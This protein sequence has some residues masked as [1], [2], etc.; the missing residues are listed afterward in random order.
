MNDLFSQIKNIFGLFVLSL[1]VACQ[2]PEYTGSAVVS[3]NL[4]DASAT[5]STITGTGPVTADGISTSTITI[6]IK[7]GYDQAMPGVTPTFSATNTGSTNTYG[8]CT[9]TDALG[10]STCT[11][12]STRAEVKTLFIVSPVLKPDGAVIFTAG[13]VSAATSTISGSTPNLADGIDTATV[14]ITL[15]DA[16]SNPISGT[17]PTFSSTGSNNTLN[18]CSASNTSGVST[19]TMSSITAE[20]KTLTLANP[21]VVTG[22]TIDFNP[23]G[24]NIQ[25]PIEMIDRGIIATTTATTF[26]RSRTSLNTDDYVAATNTYYFEIVAH[27]TH[28]TSDYTVQLYNGAGSAI[29]ATAITVP[30]NTTAGNMRRFRV[31]FTPTTGADTYRIRMPAATT[32]TLYVHSA[33]IIVEQTAATDTKIYIPLVSSDVTLDNGGD[34]S[35][36]TASTTSLAYASDSSSMSWWTRND[37]AYDAIATSNAWTFEVVGSIGNGVDT[38]TV[39]LFN[40]TT[41]QPVSVLTFTGSTSVTLSRDTFSST[42]LNFTDGH[43]YDVRYLT[44]N[45]ASPVR[46]Y[47][48][49]LWL[50]LKYLRS[51]EILFRVSGR[52]STSSAASENLLDNRTLWESTRWS[53]PTT[54]FQTVA[55]NAMSSSA[56]YTDSVNNSGTTSLA[57]IAGSSLNHGAP[58]SIQRSAAIT[59]TN[60]DRHVVRH[61]HTDT[62]TAVNMS[63]FIVVDATE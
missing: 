6:T 26:E 47:K 61:T 1:M 11:L 20:E 33:R 46:V 13:A 14:T 48:A 29:A 12:S 7:N 32:S 40:R 2:G 36:A 9:V 28:G 34:F 58:Q 43:T 54:Y 22:N 45:T 4:A 31:P 30:A 49:G 17:T 5:Y 53:N 3:T 51:A 24:I 10:V 59:L 35:A 57:L 41:T 38:G 27:N 23:N 39:T 63:S 62:S 44:S 15:L 8:A 60:G 16:F 37:A 52:F 50:K 18:A 25:V 42:K 55:S 56:L 21:V 19:C